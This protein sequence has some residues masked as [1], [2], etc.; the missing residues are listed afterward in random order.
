M[1]EK[2]IIKKTSIGDIRKKVAEC[3][4]CEKSYFDGEEYL[5]K[6]DDMPVP[7]YPLIRSDCPLPDWGDE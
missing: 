7:P 3:M 2:M 4:L 6:F 5:C 1:K